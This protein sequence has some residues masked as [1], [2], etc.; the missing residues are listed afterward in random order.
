MSLGFGFSSGQFWMTTW[1]SFD[2]P[3]HEWEC[4]AEGD[5]GEGQW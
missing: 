3:D 2:N 4:L 5:E 1:S